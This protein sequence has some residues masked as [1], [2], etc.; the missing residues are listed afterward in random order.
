MRILRWTLA[1]WVASVAGDAAVRRP[2]HSSGQKRLTQRQESFA[3]FPMD[4]RTVVDRHD[5]IPGYM[6]NDHDV[7][8]RDPREL[9]TLRGGRHLGGLSSRGSKRTSLDPTPCGDSAAPRPCRNDVA[10]QPGSRSPRPCEPATHFQRFPFRTR[11]DAP[12]T[13]RGFAEGRS[14]SL[15]LHPVPA[16]RFL[17]A[18]VEAFRPGARYPVEPPGAPSTGSF[19]RCRLIPSSTRRRCFLGVCTAIPGT[20][21]DRWMFA[22]VARPAL[23]SLAPALTGGPRTGGFLHNLRTVVLDTRGRIHRQF[24][25]KRMDPG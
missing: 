24:E 12:G 22:A 20:N 21:A 13:F 4:A 18:H 15:H 6:R 11:P 5:E 23:E 2:L 14:P 16:S 10:P 1:G 9:R 19:C 7:H 8:R 17:P 3:S 25:R